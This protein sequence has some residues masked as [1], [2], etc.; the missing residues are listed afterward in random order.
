MAHRVTQ[1]IIGL[2]NFIIGL[3]TFYRVM[4]LQ[5]QVTNSEGDNLKYRVTLTK[6]LQLICGY[7]RTV[8]GR[9]GLSYVLR[10]DGQPRISVKIFN[11]LNDYKKGR[12]QKELNIKIIHT[13]MTCPLRMEA[14]S[15]DFLQRV[16]C[17]FLPLVLF[18]QRI[19]H[20]IPPYSYVHILPIFQELKYFPSLYEDGEKQKCRNRISVIL[21]NRIRIFMI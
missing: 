8:G 14:Y 19:L 6:Q 15:F 17:D 12:I 2:H 9:R 20:K 5:Y 21:K 1:F 3:H 7:T 11:F 10:Q 16:F 18:L 4:Q 13:E